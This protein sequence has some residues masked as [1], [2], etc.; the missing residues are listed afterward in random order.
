M[1]NQLM[2]E[3]KEKIER[4]KHYFLQRPDISMV[5]VFGSY[6]KDREIFESDFDLAIYFTPR[7][8]RIEWLEN[9]FFVEE[10]QIWQDIEKILEIDTDLVVLNRAR[11]TVAFEILKTG[12]PLV[13]KDRKV[14][15]EFYLTVSR[16]AEDFR[17][18]TKDYWVTYQ[19]GRSLSEEDKA[20]LIERIQFL[21]S[22][23][24]EFPDYRN[25]TLKTYKEDKFQRRNIERWIETLVTSI[26]DVGKIVLASE[27]KKMPS[28]YMEVL[29]DFCLLSSFNE[30]EAREFAQ[31]AKLRNI[32]A[33]EY[34][35]IRF[36]QI[37]K[38]IQEAGPGY[39]KLLKFGKDFIKS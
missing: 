17:E 3:I 38:F 23:I 29:V 7:G 30:N 37:T 36:E 18:F 24:Q 26:I 11:P 13:I 19:R 27:K 16:E 22:E 12:L 33:H 4:V 32:L 20:K 28:T 8:R 14:Y 1:V 5:F 10:N 6:A 39:Q 9:Q 35:D 31:F 25:L 21:D 34:L 15:L 2:P